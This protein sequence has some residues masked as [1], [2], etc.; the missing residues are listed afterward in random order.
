[1]P[2]VT[3][4][5]NFPCANGALIPALEMTIDYAYAVAYKIQSEGIKSLY[6]L[7]ECVKDF[8]E[9]KDEFMKDTVFADN[10][11]SW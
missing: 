9:H 10:C 7:A 8:Q 4:G 6:P 11:R 1:M 3:S 5:P 2:L